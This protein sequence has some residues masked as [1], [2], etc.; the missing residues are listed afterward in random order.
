MN[1]TSGQSILRDMFGNPADGTFLAW[2]ADHGVWAIL[3]ALGAIATW[4]IVRRYIRSKFQSA[5]RNVDGSDGSVDDNGIATRS[6]DRL[7]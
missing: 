2:M 1:S 4:Y 6:F 5:V 7:L 3:I